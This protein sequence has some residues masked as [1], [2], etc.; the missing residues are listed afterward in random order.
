MLGVSRVRAWHKHSCYI[1]FHYF[2]QGLG[3]SMIS[4]SWG[5]LN[6]ARIFVLCLIFQK[7]SGADH[8]WLLINL[9]KRQKRILDDFLYLG[10]RLQIFCSQLFSKAEIFGRTLKTRDLPLGWMKLYIVMLSISSISSP[11]LFPKL[12]WDNPMLFVT[13][14]RKNNKHRLNISL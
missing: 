7:Q 1:S 8:T 3:E 6:L 11:L 9:L 13:W 2:E 10:H 4:D 14:Q 5:T 12:L